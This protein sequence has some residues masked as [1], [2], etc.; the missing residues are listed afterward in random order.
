VLI[1]QQEYEKFEA[2]RQWAH[3]CIDEAATNHKQ[4]IVTPTNEGVATHAVGTNLSLM[5]QLVFDWLDE[6][7]DDRAAGV[8]QRERT[9]GT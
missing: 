8:L 9:T 7:F 1:G 4:L 5:S 2:S 3:R 6:T